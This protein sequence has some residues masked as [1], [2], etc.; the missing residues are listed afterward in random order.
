MA[1]FGPARRVVIDLR[2]GHVFARGYALHRV[3]PY[4][5]AKHVFGE[6]AIGANYVFGSGFHTS[7]LLNDLE[8]ISG[9]SPSSSIPLPPATGVPS[10]IPSNKSENTS[11]KESS[12]SPTT[13]QSPGNKPQKAVTCN[14][15]IYTIV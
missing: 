7:F 10:P 11:L 5:T 14:L 9:K 8:V 6:T 2:R 1:S 15:E 3:T 12:L 13:S 4:V